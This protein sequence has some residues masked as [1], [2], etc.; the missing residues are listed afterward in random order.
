MMFCK[1]TTVVKFSYNNKISSYVISVGYI[2][3]KNSTKDLMF[4]C[5]L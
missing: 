5:T 2:L 1:V 4:L 3:A